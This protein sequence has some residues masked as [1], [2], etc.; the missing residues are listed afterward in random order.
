M[1]D[2]L[3]GALGIDGAQWRALVSTYL[4]MDFRAT[5]GPVRRD[6]R[7]R[8]RSQIVAIA[9]VGAVGGSAFGLIAAATADLLMSASL[10][11][12]YAAATTIM[13]LL[14]DFTGVVLAPE[15][16]AILA[17]RPISSRTYFAA[18]LAAVG[19]YVA[20]LSVATA[21]I[22]IVVYAAKG[23][24][25]A[26]A[27]ALAA[28][29]L[30]DLC[31]TV[32]VISAYVTLLRW[33]HP[34]KLKRAMGYV[35]LLGATSFYLVYYLATVGFRHSIL[36]RLGFESAPWMWIV[37]STWFAAFVRAAA[38]GAGAAVWIASGAA[39]ALTVLCVPLAAGRLSLDYARRIGEMSAV[40]EPASR[41]RV[42][43]LPGF[44]RG[45]AR[46]VALLVR[47]QF[48]F[49]QRFRMGILGIIPLTGFYMLLGLDD[50]A[51]RD[52]FLGES[53]AVGVY[54]AVIFIP[55]TLHTALAASESW[56]AAWIFFATPA[57]HAR[58]VVASKNFVTIYF[59]GTYVVA[60]AA[61]WSWFYE[62]VWH[63]AIHALILGV[64][65]HLLL[66]LAVITRPSLPFAAEPHKAQRSASTFAL[67]I[68]GGVVAG[69][70]PSLLAIIYRSAVITVATVVFLMLITA[71]VE[72][73]L[74]LRV[75]E[76]IGDLEFRS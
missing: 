2:R 33:V 38:G 24:I 44:S 9:M 48:R 19:A 42:F 74:R 68:V 45:E 25:L 72:Y 49:D 39:V 40:A 36:D 18:R 32:L 51:L 50:G 62:R 55:M 46:A 43:R 8:R 22:P 15:D 34:S 53:G 57:S 26:G 16:Y 3:A 21:A 6:G 47:A 4:R 10:L 54:F 52:P 27:A 29:L 11:T 61:F 41:R 17:P 5:G 66:Q 63:A 70:F 75:D 28:V 35:Q 56:R 71:A 23:G 76:V 59:L 20:V 13:M 69:V 37:P 7:D 30:C 58:I 1:F 73:A 60:L 14:V 67:F 12:T 64:L 31:M 65:A